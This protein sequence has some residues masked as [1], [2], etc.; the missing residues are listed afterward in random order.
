MIKRNSI[1]ISSQTNTHAVTY[2][3]SLEEV[4]FIDQVSSGGLGLA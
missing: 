2:M 4:E 3:Y 1:V